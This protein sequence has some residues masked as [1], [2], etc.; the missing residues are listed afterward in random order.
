MYPGQIHAVAKCFAH[1]QQP[2]RAG[3]AQFVGDLVQVT[4]AHLFAEVD[5][6][7]HPGFQAAQGLLQGFLERPADCHHFSHRFH[8]GREL[9]VGLGKL[10]ESEPG[11]LGNNVIDGRFE[12]G[13]RGAPGNFV[14]QFIQG[15]AYRQFRRD[16]GYREPG[17]LGGQRG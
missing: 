8:L 5:E 13:R 15:V 1:V 17:R 3:V 4:V 16:P 12:R 7:V 9:R 11:D 6:T 14:I 2:F 10:L